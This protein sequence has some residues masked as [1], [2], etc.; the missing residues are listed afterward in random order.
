LAL[1]DGIRER[2]SGLLKP[3]GQKLDVLTGSERQDFLREAADM[4]AG[5]L[6][7]YSLF[8]DYYEGEHRIRLLERAKKYLEASGLPYTE[9]FCETIVDV[10]AQ[11]LEVVG[12]KV[13]HNAD[14]SDWLTKTVW[15]KNGM[16][17]RQGIVH[18]QTTVKGDGFIIVTFDPVTGLPKNTWNR[19]EIIKPVYADDDPDEMLY[20]CKVWTT[21]AVSPTN[22]NGDVVNRLNIYFPDR[23]EKWFAVGSKDAGKE[24]WAPHC[25]DEDV[26]D[27]AAV[28]PIPWTTTGD[29]EGEPIGIPVV[30]FRNKPKGRTFGR[31]EI[32]GTI[33]QQEA[34]TKQLVDLFYVMDSQ[35]W[36]QRWA[37]GV[38]DNASL[39]VAIGEFLKAS[40][41]QAKFGQFTAEN[42]GPMGEQIEGTLRRMAAR[43]QTPLHLLM[44]GGT[45]PSGESLKAAES[46]LVHKAGDRKTTHGGS[47]SKVQKL[48]IRVTHVFGTLPFTF[49]EE[50]EIETVWADSESRNEQAETN[51]LGVQV[52]LLGLSKTTALRKL[53][54]DPEEEQK[55]RDEEKE[56]E[57]EP[58]APPHFPPSVVTDPKIP[59]PAPIIHT[60]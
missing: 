30:H 41:E 13:E 53:G 18:T 40:N 48:N 2:L 44:T 10:L 16:D 56:A 38:D 9:N 59:P 21:A 19:P 33:P 46:P 12:F 35:G 29:V 6:S 28:W 8:E 49:D 26:V 5:R 57:P 55:N 3:S 42:P 54:Y 25:D 17:E 37:T 24:V 11:R 14:A 58:P 15:P 27:G 32:R 31:S 34:L 23:V 20:A 45:L 43:A 51:T 60:K 52:E 36:Q 7:K 1:A 47:W 50:A 39:N 4:G 22:P